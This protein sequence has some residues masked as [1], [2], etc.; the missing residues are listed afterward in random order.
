MGAPTVPSS[1]KA[2]IREA[3]HGNLI[4]SGGYDR[5]RAEAD[6]AADHADF[7]AFG[8]PFI[9]NPDLVE[10]LR[11]GGA[12]AEADPETFYTSGEAGYSDYPAL[13]V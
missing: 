12:L 2:A 5:A 7:I 9:A 8:R 10:L 3:F 13:V 11:T 4:L 1:T 6:L